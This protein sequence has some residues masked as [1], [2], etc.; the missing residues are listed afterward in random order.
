MPFWARVSE[1]R[2]MTHKECPKRVLHI[3]LDVAAAGMAFQP[4]DAVGVCPSNEPHL[5]DE[6]LSILTIDGSQCA[7]LPYLAADPDQSSLSLI[8]RCCL[9]QPLLLA[10]CMYDPPAVS[11][12]LHA[13]EDKS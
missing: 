1:N 9:L 3:S 13:V 11:L 7:P 12:S 5:V 6:L 4:G 10:V 2:L 8:L